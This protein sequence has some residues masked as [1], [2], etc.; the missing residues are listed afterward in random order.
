M[1]GIE[2]EISSSG[3]NEPNRD[4]PL[5]LSVYRF[6]S[7]CAYPEN[8]AAATTR[9][10]S[11]THQ[12]ATPRRKPT[13]TSSRGNHHRIANIDEGRG[14]KKRHARGAP[15]FPRR[16]PRGGDAIHKPKLGW[17]S[18]VAVRIGS[19][20]PNSSLNPNTG[21]DHPDHH[22]RTCLRYNLSGISW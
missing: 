2:H 12:K 4:I 19:F 21:R 7:R 11:T 5:S 9:K 15:L 1:K 20:K 8:H 10:A 17:S 13:T 14:S 18:L 6:L 22:T 16:R 3:H